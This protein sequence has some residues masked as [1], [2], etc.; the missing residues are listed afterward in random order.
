MDIK[1]NRKNVLEYLKEFKKIIPKRN[2]IFS[3]SSTVDTSKLDGIKDKI[4]LFSERGILVLP[5]SIDKNSIDSYMENVKLVKQFPNNLRPETLMESEIFKQTENAKNTRRILLPG[6]VDENLHILENYERMVAYYML[7]GGDKPVERFSRVE[8]SMKKYSVSPDIGVAI[9]KYGDELTTKLEELA[10][11]KARSPK[12]WEFFKDQVLHSFMTAEKIGNRNVNK[13]EHS[14]WEERL[15]RLGILERKI[16]KTEER[17]QT[18]RESL[19]YDVTKNDPDKDREKIALERTLLRKAE[20]QY[21]NTGAIPLGY[22]KDEQ[23]R[24]VRNLPEMQN[25]RTDRLSA[26]PNSSTTT[27]TQKKQELTR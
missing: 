6:I 10:T 17:K 3:R 9:M 1:A 11:S 21:I 14:K 22:K 26:S 19:K 23:G 13:E 4:E 25:K 16:D 18:F 7:M 27:K 12:E 20:Q 24:I 5:M 2:T 15:I 8:M